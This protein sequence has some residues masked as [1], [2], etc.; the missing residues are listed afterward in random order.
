MI[1]YYINYRNYPELQKYFAVD[2]LTGEL[3]VNLFGGNELD[4]DS[5]ESEHLIRVDFEDNFQGNGGLL[6]LLLFFLKK[7]NSCFNKARN[8]DQT[9]V[10]LILKDV[11]DNA[12]Q[13]PT[14]TSAYEIDE[15]AD[16]VKISN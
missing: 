16:E 9:T 4:R 13:M 1:Q 8:K 11:N 10:R 14:R 12:P 3:T 15:N 2:E 6:N 7:L 5:D